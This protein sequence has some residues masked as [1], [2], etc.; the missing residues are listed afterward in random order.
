MDGAQRI[1]DLLR[2]LIAARNPKLD[3]RVQA[4]FAKVD[5]LLALYRNKDRQ[6]SSYD[7]L[8]APRPQTP[9]RAPSPLWP[10]ISRNCA[11]PSPSTEIA[12]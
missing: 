8:F 5:G 10:R 7:K 12:S 6:M 2:P 4:N 1:F 11:A 9:S 3:A